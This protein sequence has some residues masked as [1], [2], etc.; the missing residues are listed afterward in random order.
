[1][2]E[3]R[4][5]LPQRGLA[6]APMTGV[7]AVLAAILVLGL[8]LRV[9]TVALTL[10]GVSRDVARFQ[11][12]SAFFGAGFTTS[13]SESVMNHPVRRRIVQLLIV[14][15]AVGLTGIV[16]SSVLTLTRQDD[17]VL[18]SLALLLGGFALIYVVFS[19]QPVDRLLV[20][21]IERL[22]RRYT[23]LQTADY[24]ALLR[25]SADYSV[26]RLTVRPHGILDGR[27]LAEFPPSEGM[28]LLGIERGDGTYVGA[29]SI[30]T[31]V[32]AG[33]TLTVYG[34]DETLGTL[35]RRQPGNV[36]D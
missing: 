2:V 19:I 28:V 22:L 18:A 9:G 21:V 3:A 8:I 16:G 4:H 1:V 12:R 27:S 35:T 34:R 7:F 25:L 14:W 15:G 11:V 5:I 29:P 17:G 13:E 23:D 10:T 33:D 6:C 36:P 32:H 30:A 26:T 31:T 24:D 20:R